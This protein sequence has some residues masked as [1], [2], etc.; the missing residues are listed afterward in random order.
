MEL[1]QVSGLHLPNCS[2]ASPPNPRE[3][4]TRIRKQ[5]LSRNLR[6]LRKGTKILISPGVSQKS[7]KSRTSRV[8]DFL[9]TSNI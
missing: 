2:I 3:K 9:K 4:T 5:I 8:T 6:H 1:K 7:M